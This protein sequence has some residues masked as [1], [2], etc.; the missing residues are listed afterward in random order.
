MNT[1]RGRQTSSTVLKLEDSPVSRF[2]FNDVRFACVWLVL[3]LYAGYEWVMA[4][5]EKLHSPI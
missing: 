5:W 2:L 4:G 3:R 1:M